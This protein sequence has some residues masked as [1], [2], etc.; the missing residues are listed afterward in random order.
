MRKT[1]QDTEAIVIYPIP[2]PSANAGFYWRVRPP[3]SLR[4]RYELDGEEMLWAESMGQLC[5]LLLN[6]SRQKQQEG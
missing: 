2:E 4:D 6:F 3:R 1:L 5:D